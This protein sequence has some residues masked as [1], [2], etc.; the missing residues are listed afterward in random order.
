M[1]IVCEVLSIV[2][3]LSLEFVDEDNHCL[4]KVVTGSLT[5]RLTKEKFENV[6]EKLLNIIRLQNSLVCFL[7]QLAA[8]LRG[9]RSK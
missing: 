7:Q 5:Q 2:N 8:T 3:R 6:A 4:C 9:Q 1:S